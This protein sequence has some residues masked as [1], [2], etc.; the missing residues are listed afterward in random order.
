MTLPSKKCFWF[1]FSFCFIACIEQVIGKPF[2]GQR[3]KGWITGG[4]IEG[5]ETVEQA[6]PGNTAWK[7]LFIQGANI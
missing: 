7:P 4:E 1:S 6:W 3:K 5:E 2:L